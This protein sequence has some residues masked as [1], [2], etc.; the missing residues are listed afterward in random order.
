[1]FLKMLQSMI[2]TAG[3]FR[4]QFITTEHERGRTIGITI[5][6]PTYPDLHRMLADITI[7]IPRRGDS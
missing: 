4:V 6:D 5:S 1:M 7:E 2:P 3:D